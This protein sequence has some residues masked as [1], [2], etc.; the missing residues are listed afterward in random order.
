MNDL[1]KKNDPFS[2]GRELRENNNYEISNDILEKFG[3]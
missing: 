3:I 2:L 1:T